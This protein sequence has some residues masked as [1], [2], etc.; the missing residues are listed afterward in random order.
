M[1][2]LVRI[3]IDGD[4]NSTDY[5]ETLFRIDGATNWTQQIDYY[6]LPIYQ[7]VSPAIDSAY[8]GLQ[9]LADGT[10]YEYQVRRFNPDGQFSE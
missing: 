2:Q 1:A 3:Y 6:P 5:Y 7:S 8:I 9:P 4:T 10:D